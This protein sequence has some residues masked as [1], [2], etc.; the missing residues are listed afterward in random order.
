MFAGDEDLVQGGM[1]GLVQAANN[2]DKNKSEFST[3]AVPAIRNAVLIELKKKDK[4]K[5]VIS[6]DTSTVRVK[7]DELPIM[8]CIIGESDIDY[9]DVDSLIKRLNDKDAEVL[10][11][12]LS[13]MTQT[14]I[15]KKYGVSREA[16]RQRLVR[17]RRV[18]IKNGYIE[19]HK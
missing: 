3:Y 19:R 4:H 17:I 9:V 2:W 14:Q 15:A 12:R 8:D 10:K 5:S 1:L 7:G 6:L 13:G 16:I 18:A 11:L